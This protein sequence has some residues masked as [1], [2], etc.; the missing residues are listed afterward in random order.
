MLSDKIT[1]RIIEKIEKKAPSISLELLVIDENIIT[2]RVRES[3][4]K[5]NFKGRPIKDFSRFLRGIFEGR[6]YYSENKN[7]FFLF[8]PIP[9]LSADYKTKIISITTLEL[10][11]HEINKICFGNYTPFFLSKIIVRQMKKN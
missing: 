5:N 7:Q 6:L 9:D 4:R 1:N 11:V 10:C 8:S 3:I 2:K